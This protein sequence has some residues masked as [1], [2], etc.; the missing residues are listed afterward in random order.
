MS[1]LSELGLRI[2]FF[3]LMLPRTPVM[4]L[5]VE[6]PGAARRD[7]FLAFSAPAWP[8]AAP[9]ARNEFAAFIDV[10]GRLQACMSRFFAEL[11]HVSQSPRA[12]SPQPARQSRSPASARGATGAA[13]KGLRVCGPVD[14]VVSGRFG[15]ARPGHRHGGTDIA[16]AAGSRIR[17]VKGGTISFAGWQRGYGLCVQVDHGGGLSTFYAHCSRIGVRAGQRVDAGDCI[18]K[19]GSTGHSSGPHLH[20]EARQ[21]GKRVDPSGFLAVVKRHTRAA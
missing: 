20:F 6:Q 8:E 19:V 11:A 14:G 7:D 4:P 1:Y 10:L 9:S 13:C 2:A 18:A 17:A 21:H 3:G 15:E 16:A 5:D 12:R